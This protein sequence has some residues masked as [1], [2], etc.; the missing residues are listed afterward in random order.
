M[1]SSDLEEAERWYLAAAE[2][3]SHW[4]MYAC[5]LSAAA[6]GDDE[7]AEA[8]HRKAAEC[9]FLPAIH[10]GTYISNAVQNGPLGEMAMEDMPMPM[11]AADAKESDKKKKVVVE[12]GFDPKKLVSY[13][14]NPKY[15]L[16]EQRRELDL[17][18][19]L[20]GM[21]NA[22]SDAQVEAVIK[23]MEIAYRMQ[24]EAPED[25]KSTR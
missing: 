24:T 10:Q 11:P 7:S 4:A 20:E 9:G 13:V 14:N 17:L 22:S 1:C 15:S 16:T 21:R 8:F 23:S 12:K 25:R 6:K 19:K 5:A 3:G 2:A 18:N